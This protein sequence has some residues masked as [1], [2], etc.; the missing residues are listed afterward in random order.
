MEDGRL[1][2]CVIGSRPRSQHRNVVVVAAE[3]GIALSILAGRSAL[4]DGLRLFRMCFAQGPVILV[5]KRCART[6][7]T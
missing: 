2:N 4:L 3:G 7:G 1:W 5:R 6:L